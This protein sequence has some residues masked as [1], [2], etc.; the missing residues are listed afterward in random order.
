[1]NL[2]STIQRNM[3]C[4]SDQTRLI[5]QLSED[6]SII[7]RLDDKFRES[8]QNSLLN[9][10]G[11]N[12]NYSTGMNRKADVLSTYNPGYSISL[13]YCKSCISW[14]HRRL[15]RKS[16]SQ[17]NFEAKTKMSDSTMARS[18]HRNVGK[19]TIFKSTS[20]CLPMNPPAPGPLTST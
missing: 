4:N 1:M 18:L 2:I 5:N 9:D 10:S 13:S 17:S 12:W 8:E 15:Y 6:I 14:L 16:Q 3:N 19:R 11:K 7:Y 20:P